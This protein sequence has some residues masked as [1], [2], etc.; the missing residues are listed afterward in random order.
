MAIENRLSDRRPF[1]VFVAIG[2]WSTIPLLIHLAYVGASNRIARYDVFGDPVNDGDGWAWLKAMLAMVAVVGTMSALAAVDVLRSRHEEAQS[3]RG[4][5]SALNLLPSA[6]LWLVGGLFA[7]IAL[8][9][10]NDCGTGATTPCLDK[11]GTVLMVLS[12][13]CLILP[14]PILALACWLGR[15][16]GVCPALAPP[17]IAGFYLMAVHLQLPHVGWGDV[18]G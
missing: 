15:R 12:V 8:T 18:L 9:F 1:I 14:T 6:I 4:N 10:V 16:S 2:G 17:T 13:C 5:G 3:S 11:P 7:V